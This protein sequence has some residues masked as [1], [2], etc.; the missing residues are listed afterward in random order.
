[1]PDTVTPHA[2]SNPAPSAPA[3]N[4]AFAAAEVGLFVPVYP[5]PRLELV[6]G[7]GTRVTDVAGRQYLDFVSG[8]A[9]NAFGHA[10]AGLASAV[11]KQMRAL[12]HCSNLFANAPAL[13]LAATLCRVTGYDRVFFCNSGAEGIETALK[14]AR[15]RAVAKGLPG[16][17]IVAF[18]G[19]FHG[20][21]GFALSTTWTPSYREPFEPLIPGVR[22]ADYNKFQG[23]DATIDA[24][25]AAVIV[26]P[27]QGEGGAVASDKAFLRSVRDR[28]SAVGAALIFDEIQ[29]GM[30]RSGHL[31]AA[32]HF[33]LTADMTV[34]SKALGGGIPLAAVL[35]TAE[36]AETLKPGMHGCTFG[37]NPVAAAA[38]NWV[39][40]RV[41]KP[42]FLA[43]VRKRSRELDAGLKALVA[44]HASLA[45]APG[46]GLLRAVEFAPDA[47]FTPADVVKAA[48][49]H[50]LLLV[51]G[52]ERAVRLLPPLTVT[53]EEIAEALALLDVALT[54]L[55]TKGAAR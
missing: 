53:S 36:V 34:L 9:V 19:G 46:L 8:I 28:A 44:K 16:R 52:G 4:D 54:E 3:A 40:E 33:G 41:A 42:G 25:V 21:T 14:F 43:R 2:P 10:P 5:L 6:S 11:A 12:G 18:R 27:V 24:N 1:M 50:G 7:K 55:E 51:R 32:E 35:T 20:R 13:K 30:G 38:G 23:L 15:A 45:T 39:I 37:G 47:A 49:R 26:E 29:C 17:D 48:M 22:F 31:L